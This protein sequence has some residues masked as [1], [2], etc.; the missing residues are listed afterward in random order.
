MIKF[1][2]VG[3]LGRM[4]VAIASLS[5]NNKNLQFTSGFSS[6]ES[7][8][9]GKNYTEITGIK[10]FNINI[11]TLKSESDIKGLDGIIDFSSP[12]STMITLSACQK[13]LVPLVIGTT[14]LSKDQQ[15]K[16]EETSQKIP[17]V[18]ASN[19]SIGINLLFSLVKKAAAAL[20]NKDY[21]PEIT[22]IHHKFKKDSPSGTAKTLEEIILKEFGWSN[23]HVTYNREGLIGERPEKELGVFSLRGGNVVGEHSTFFFGDHETIELKHKASSRDAFAKGALSALE[24]LQ[25]KPSRLYTMTDVLSLDS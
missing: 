23:K 15:N 6:S 10:N 2:I 17:I 13:A 4:G 22:E 16:I 11:S 25:N 5:K 20:K 7:R 9:I 24:F 12:E 19:M 21:N 1:G 18:F 14:G 8:N 3:C